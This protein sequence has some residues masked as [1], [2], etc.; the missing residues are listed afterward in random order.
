MRQLV[1]RTALLI[2]CTTLAF[3]GLASSG[4]RLAAQGT[5]RYFPETGHTVKNRFL[6]YWEQHGGLAQQG[7]PLTDEVQERSDIDGK[8][9]TMQYFERAVFELHPEN[10]PPYD[11]L[12]SL[13]GVLEYSLYGP[14]GKPG[15]VASKDN[16]RYFPETKHTL[17]GKFRQ[18][19]ES[20]GGLAQQGYPISDEFS[21]RSSLD[22]KTYRVQ[23]FQRAEFELHPEYA[24]TPYEVL[25]TQLGRQQ[26]G[27]KH[28]PPTPTA[29]PTVTGTA[30]PTATPLVPPTP[31]PAPAQNTTTE[32]NA[33]SMVSPTEGW[34]VGTISGVGQPSNKA[35]GLI[36]HYKG[37]KWTPVSSPTEPGQVLTDIDMVSP[38]EG[39]A[40]GDDTILHYSNGRWQSYLYPG[41][42]VDELVALSMVD[43]T[44]GWAV[45]GILGP[46]PMYH[47]KDGKWQFV[48]PPTY[49][50]TW[51]IQMLSASDGWLVGGL[52]LFH[53]TGG[54]W[55]AVSTPEGV[56]INSI[57]MASPMEG[58]ASGSAIL[59]YTD[60]QWS[61]A[62][63][64]EAKTLGLIRMVSTSDGWATGVAPDSGNV[65]RLLHYDGDKWSF[66]PTPKIPN[67]AI[68]DLAMTSA[69]EGWAVGGMPG[70]DT[71]T[72]L[73]LERYAILHYQNGIWSLYP[74]Q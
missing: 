50:P 11:V 39:W 14:T 59:H 47:Y 16:P 33:I 51:E 55:V 73:T 15:Q 71:G 5:Q 58:W 8:V 72:S 57:G 41:E 10:A 12:L 22:G 53:Y 28:P 62:T 40:V 2:C 19:W 70:G 21:E 27:R 4:M 30:T 9:Y 68:Y 52:K 74:N 66:Y 37:G 29:T 54:Q 63:N 48:K 64:S 23:Y 69:S 46:A 24:N 56:R 25:L 17:G 65:V 34:A 18:Y 31:S 44:E 7:Y 43:S 32:L 20:H 26:Y 3:P 36:L 35:S 38:T 13:L 61:V 60:G 42:H 6:S 1:T 45:G 67:L 49:E